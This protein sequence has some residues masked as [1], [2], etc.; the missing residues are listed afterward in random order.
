MILSKR[1]RLAVILS[2]AWLV[3]GG[4]ILWVLPLYLYPVDV[5]LPTPDQAGAGQ[6]LWAAQPRLLILMVPIAVVW[7]VL[8][9]ASWVR[10]GASR[11][12]V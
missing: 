6:G 8:L 4:L 7:V 3:A 1:T 5:S 10:S 12:N 11:G 9:V 2:F